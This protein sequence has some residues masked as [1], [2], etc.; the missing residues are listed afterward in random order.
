[1]AERFQNC[2]NLYPETELTQWILRIENMTSKPRHIIIKLPIR[3]NKEKIFKYTA[4]KTHYI[5]SDEEKNSNRLLIGN[6][7]GKKRVDHL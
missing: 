6:N 2:C 7:L 5:Q 4:K 1:M 3:N